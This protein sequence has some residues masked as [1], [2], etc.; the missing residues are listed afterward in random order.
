MKALIRG[1]GETV[2]EGMNI[3]GIDW[4][5]GAPLTN[6]DWCG[7]PYRLVADYVESSEQVSIDYA[8]ANMVPT[9]T[10]VKPFETITLSADDIALLRKVIG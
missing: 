3:D 2:T 5:T 1:D 9:E 6:A 7:G 4:T 10:V 8:A